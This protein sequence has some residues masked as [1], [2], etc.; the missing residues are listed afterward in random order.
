ME[1]VKLTLSHIK[2]QTFRLINKEDISMITLLFLP[3]NMHLQ[4]HHSTISQRYCVR[5]IQIYNSNTCV[6]IA[7][8][9]VIRYP[10]QSILTLF[11]LFSVNSVILHI[12]NH[13][14][15]SQFLKHN[16]TY[17][18]LIPKINKQLLKINIK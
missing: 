2:S 17:I 5:I 3:L 8:P 6:M 16:N 10:K 14:Q 13:I 12:R 18:K 11:L 1:S 15:F 9:I 4:I 7:I